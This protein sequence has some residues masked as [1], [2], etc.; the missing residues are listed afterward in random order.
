MGSPVSVT[1][2]DLVM[3]D[4]EQR[5]LSMYPYLLPSGRDMLMTLAWHFP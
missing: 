2:A 4:V 1:V 5:A 3:E